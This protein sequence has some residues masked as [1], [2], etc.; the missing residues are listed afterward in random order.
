MTM[1]MPSPDPD[2]EQVDEMFAQLLGQ[3]ESLDL[4]ERAVQNMGIVVV[5]SLSD[6]ELVEKYNSTKRELY[7]REELL[8]ARTEIGRDLHSIYHACLLELKKRGLQ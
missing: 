5:S 4:G 7:D 8:E 3:M 2:D 1:A 6:I